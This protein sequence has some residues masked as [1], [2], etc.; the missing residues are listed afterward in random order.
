MAMTPQVLFAKVVP[1][2]STALN[3]TTG[4]AS[5]KVW[6]VTKMRIVNTHATVD[7]SCVITQEIDAVDY[8]LT[9]AELL[10]A[11]VK[12]DVM[13]IGPFVLDYGNNLE[14]TTVGAA[15]VFHIVAY[16]YEMDV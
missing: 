12:E 4:P 2:V 13:E 16:G 11:I 3:V 6:V 15:V 1:A 9:V 14:A 10:T 8:T 5:G 7:G